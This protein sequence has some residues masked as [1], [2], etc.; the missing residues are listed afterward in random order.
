MY[1]SI[2]KKA[3]ELACIMADHLATLSPEQRKAR[4][5]AGDEV[6]RKAMKRAKG[7]GSA[8]IGRTTPSNG[9]MLRSP[10][11]ARGR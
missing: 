10:L 4:I 5:K 8:D 3:E 9:Q 1:D 2:D 7:S 6:L 11:A